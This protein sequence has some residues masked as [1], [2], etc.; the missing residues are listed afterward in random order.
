MDLKFE[1]ENVKVYFSESDTKPL[2][3]ACNF[4][5]DLNLTWFEISKVD[6]VEKIMSKFSKNKINSSNTEFNI[7]YL[8]KA[9][10]N[11]KI[12]SVIKNNLYCSY[13]EFLKTN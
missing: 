5:S 6:F 7:N 9:F 8:I 12:R 1:Y 10:D 3:V 13:F 4:N 2:F 11:Y